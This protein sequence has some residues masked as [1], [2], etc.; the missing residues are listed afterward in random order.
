[1]K[2]LEGERTAKQAKLEA[3][4]T[5]LRKKKDALDAKRSVAK[6]DPKEEQALLADAQKLTQEF[7]VEQQRL[8]LTEKNL[9]DQMLGRIELVVREIAV[10]QDLDFVFERG[11][12]LTP[13]VLYGAGVRDL[14]PAVIKLYQSRF[15]KGL[16]LS[17]SR[18]T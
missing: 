11:D 15:K 1:M 14:T 12:D 6:V 18:P 7:M 10:A 2:T 5:D 3:R 16:D 4:Q 17:G 13:T 9:T 8:T